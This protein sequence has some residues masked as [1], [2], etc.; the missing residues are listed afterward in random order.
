M[1][2]DDA[3]DAEIQQRVHRF[4]VIDGPDVYLDSVRMGV[5]KQRFRDERA[6]R[7]FEGDLE[8]H[9]GGLRRRSVDGAFHHCQHVF[10]TRSKCDGQPSFS[11]VTAQ[12]PC[13]VAILR[14][15]QGEGGAPL[16]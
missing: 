6:V 2:A 14:G 4:L 15:Q 13:G 8:R 5:S 11:E 10:G 16:V 7:E 1:V 12:A 9:R 3:I